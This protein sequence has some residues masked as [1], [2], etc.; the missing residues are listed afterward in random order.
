MRKSNIMIVV[1]I[2]PR[3]FTNLARQAVDER[4]NEEKETSRAL[5]NFAHHYC[6]DFINAISH[7]VPPEVFTANLSWGH[8]IMFSYRV[9]ISFHV[10]FISVGI[11]GFTDSL[12][13]TRLIVC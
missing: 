8:L 1:N 10:V 4:S 6:L 2:V 9:F 3:S 7:L 11:G 5:L 13:K 12:T